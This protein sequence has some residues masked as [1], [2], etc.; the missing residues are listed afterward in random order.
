[1]GCLGV[2]QETSLSQKGLLKKKKIIYDIND[3]RIQK[4]HIS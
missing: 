2:L 3:A 1:M 4:I